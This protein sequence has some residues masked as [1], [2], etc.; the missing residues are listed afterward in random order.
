MFD[1]DLVNLEVLANINWVFEITM[2]LFKRFDGNFLI[3]SYYT[4]AIMKVF[5]YFTKENMKYNNQCLR[6]SAN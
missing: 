2:Q 5:F 6:Y 1:L 3:Y 4:T